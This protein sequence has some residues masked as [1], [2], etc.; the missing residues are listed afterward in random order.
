MQEQISEILVYLKGTLK[1]KWVAMALAWIVC[2][3]GWLFVLAMPNKYTSEAKVHVETRTMLQP[4][5][6]GMTVQSD[7]RALLRVMQLLMFTKYNLEQIINL[8]DLDKDVKD[9]ADLLELI[10][11][12]KKDIQILGG[13]DDIFT[14][15]YEADNP[16]TAKSVV[17]AVLTVFSE[18]TQL[19]TLSGMDEAHHFIDEQIHEY[20]TRLRNA[21]RNRENFKRA[22]FGMLPGQ[23]GDQIGQIQQLSASLE[24]AKL[25]LNEAI[26]RKDALKM[27]MDEALAAEDDEDWGNLTG[28]QADSEDARITELKKRRDDLLIK[29]TAKHPEIVYIDKTIQKLEKLNAEKEAN[30]EPQEEGRLDTA[31]MTNPYVQTI[32]V[33]MNDADA[34]IA[35]IRSRVE[36]YEKRLKTAQD[37][38]N[39]RLSVETEIQNLNRDYETIKKNYDHLL[40]S[41]EQATMS[42]KVDDQ[43]EALKFKI[44]DA[45]NTPLEPSSPNR[46]LLYSVI[47]GAGTVVGLGIAFFVYLLRPTVMS[48]TQLRHLTGLPVLGTVSLKASPQQ[49]EKD[50][51]ESLRYNFAILGLILVYSGFMTI[52]ILGIRFSFLSRLLQSIH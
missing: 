23:A 44:A 15:K 8:A 21:E 41:R 4:L 29:Y 24:E 32:K 45:P 36:L 13:G 52:D 27:Q 16:D 3:G 28:T 31:V 5:L 48:A 9:S 14:I 7:I 37:E 18:Q 6:S 46:K 33:A 51:K 42:K 50:K 47:L 39:T 12:L 38:L 17:Q 25:K 20:E 35:S 19:S 49:A 10:E 26:S 22:N 2:L 11:R 43:A 34:T 1:Y 40:Q 30:L